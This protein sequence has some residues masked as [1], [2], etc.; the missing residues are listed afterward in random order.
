ML[1]AWAVSY[2]VDENGN[3]DVA[4]GGDAPDG[5][6]DLTKPGDGEIK[7]E[8][9]RQKR[10]ARMAM[11][12]EYILKKIDEA[13][14]MRKP[15]WDGVRALLLILPLTEGAFAYMIMSLADFRHFE[16]CREISNVR[17]GNIPG[18]HPVLVYW[19]WI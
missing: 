12:V 17:S 7:R 6:I 2:G 11:V 18:V 1:Y 13:G 9:D 19:S 4:E 16:P 15:T 14:L 5:P 10:W 3:L 8:A